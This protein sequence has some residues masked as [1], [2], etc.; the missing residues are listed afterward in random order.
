MNGEM[1]FIEKLVFHT[2]QLV[3]SEKKYFLKV[4]T[5]DIP[6]KINFLRFIQIKHIKQFYNHFAV[7]LREAYYNL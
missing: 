3:Q 1:L 6:I 5:N 2:Y 7:P 4:C